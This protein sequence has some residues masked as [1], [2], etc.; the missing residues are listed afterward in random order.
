M[1]SDIYFIL[2]WTGQVPVSI[3]ELSVSYCAMKYRQS[4]SRFFLAVVTP[5]KRQLLLDGLKSQYMEE[6]IISMHI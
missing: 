2:H 1:Y 6:L 4:H 3:E 5:F